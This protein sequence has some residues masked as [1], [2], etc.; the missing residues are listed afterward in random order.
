[1]K[2]AGIYL[3]F[4]AISGLLLWG[5]K[6]ARME[7]AR[8]DEIEAAGPR[9]TSHY[10]QALREVEAAERTNAPARA[11]AYARERAHEAQSIVIEI[12]FNNMLMEHLLVSYR[13]AQ[14]EQR[15]KIATRLIELSTTN[16]LHWD[17]FAS[18]FKAAGTNYQDKLPEAHRWPGADLGFTAW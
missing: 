16:M 3:V 12:R 18:A 9:P 13:V 15:R 11:A 10:A 2:R 5:I 1:M 8:L 17:H 14:G 7:N 6:S 4:L